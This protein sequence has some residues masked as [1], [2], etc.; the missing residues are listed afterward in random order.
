MTVVAPTSSL[1][2]DKMDNLLP[3]VPRD[4]L[5]DLLSSVPRDKMDKNLLLLIFDQVLNMHN[6]ESND[7]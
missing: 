7:L 5:V 1:P 3:S 4:K 6:I 2:R